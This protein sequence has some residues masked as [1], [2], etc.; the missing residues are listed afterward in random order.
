MERL[1]KAL[2]TGDAAD[3]QALGH[4][5]KGTLMVFSAQNAIAAAAALE[6]LG[7]RGDLKATADPLAALESEVQTLLVELNGFLQESS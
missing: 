3:V 5:L 6:D 4:A 7:R 2:Q 1:R